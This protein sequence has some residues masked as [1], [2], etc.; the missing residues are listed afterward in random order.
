MAIFL[1]DKLEELFNMASKERITIEDNNK[2]V[3]SVVD[4]IMQELVKVTEDLKTSHND[5][6]ELPIIRANI[7]RINNTVNSVNSK[8]TF[9]GEH[10][11]KENAVV[12]LLESRTFPKEIYEGLIPVTKNK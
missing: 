5:E 2:F 9:L 4:L 12:L 7:K 6:T 11:L 8:Y 1:S 10:A 3:K